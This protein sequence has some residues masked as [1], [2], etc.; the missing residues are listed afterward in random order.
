[1]DDEIK[2]AAYHKYSF[3]QESTWEGKIEFDSSNITNNRYEASF[4]LTES[5][6]VRMSF[7]P[8]DGSSIT[9]LSVD[10]IANY[11]PRLEKI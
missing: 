4:T 5:C 10:I 7:L 2:C 8:A 11:N 1:M 9:D 6:Y 3:T